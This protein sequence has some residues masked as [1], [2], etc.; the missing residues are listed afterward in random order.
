M[1]N[2]SLLLRSFRDYIPYRCKWSAVICE[3]GCSARVVYNTRIPCTTQ[4]TVLLIHD[5]LHIAYNMYY[6]INSI[7]MPII[8]SADGL[9]ESYVREYV[10]CIMYDGTAFMQSLDLNTKSASRFSISTTHACTKLSYM[11]R[12]S[13]RYMYSIE[14]TF[15]RSL[16]TTTTKIQRKQNGKYSYRI[17]YIDERMR[18]EFLIT[19]KH[20]IQWKKGMLIA[21]AYYSDCIHRESSSFEYT[22]WNQLLRIRKHTIHQSTLMHVPRW[23]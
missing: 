8:C 7:I 16:S 20:K 10:I 5:M 18:T 9:F 14:L 19:T 22:C 23:W 17:E 11:Y 12:Y 21:H 2:K 3:S 6:V 13:G 15:V 1:Q 4:Y